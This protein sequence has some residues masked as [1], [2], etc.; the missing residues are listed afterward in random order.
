MVPIGDLVQG[1]RDV[2][3][4]RCQH[5]WRATASAATDA[6]MSFDGVAPIPA[7]FGK[8]ENALGGFFKP[9]LR[10][11]DPAPVAERTVT[12]MF[13]K[14]PAESEAL[15]PHTVKMPRRSEKW[16]EIL[17]FVS[18]GVIFITWAMFDREPIVKV[19]PV[20]RGFYDGIG[21]H[22]S[23]AWDGLMFDHVKSEFKYD[24]GTMK[25]LVDGVIHNSTAE[26]QLIPD[27]KARAIGPDGRVI[28]SWWVPP[29]AATIGVGGDV[30]FHTEV[31]EPME[32][33]IDNVNLEFFIRD[34][35]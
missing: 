29:P 25:L 1:G 13:F 18:L 34:D 35:K 17:F 23:P 21:L 3:C 15:Q 32:H 12:D 14:T 28:Q 11:D 24:A 19:L 20:L 8:A 16:H 31:A 2:R 30:P 27:I 26:A 33:T 6:L 7:T 10:R 22:V 4:A 5:G 9:E